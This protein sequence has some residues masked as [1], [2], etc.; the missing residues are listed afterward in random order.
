MTS[1]NE[2]AVELASRAA[3]A[4]GSQDRD[5]RRSEDR[6]GTSGGLES[7]IRRARNGRL[8][9]RSNHVPAVTPL[10]SDR[11]GNAHLRRRNAMGCWRQ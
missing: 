10:R 6:E 2:Q 1:C 5:R 8:D 4:A 7:G 11:A 9:E 3:F